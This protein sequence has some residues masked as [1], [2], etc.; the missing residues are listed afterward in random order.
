M[1]RPV[2]V[3]I[4]GTDAQGS[5]RQYGREVKDGTA[6][7]FGRFGRIPARHFDAVQAAVF[8]LIGLSST[9][10][11]GTGADYRSRGL[12]GI[13]LMGAVTLP[14]AWRRRAPLTVFLITGSAIVAYSLSGRYEGLLPFAVL[15]GAYTVGSLAP[16]RRVLVAAAASLAF[17]AILLAGDAPGFD[18]SVFLFNAVMFGAALM[19]GFSIQSRRLRLA[20]LE[21]AQEATVSRA[22]TDERLRIARELHD[23][24]A[25]SLGVIAVQAGAGM[26]VID[27]DPDEAR[28]SLEHI[29]RT[30]RSSL[31]EI[32]RLLAAVRDGEGSPGYVP[33]PGLAD[34]GRL[35]DETGEAGLPVRLVIDGDTTAVPQG[36][37]LAAYRIVQEALTNTIRH[38]AASQAHVRLDGS[39]GALR[40]EV[41]DDGRGPDG[42]AR[43]DG[44]GLVGMRERVTIYG[45]TLE[46]GSG[47]AGGFRVSVVLP[48]EREPVG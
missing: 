19:F 35:V 20:A 5:S 33:A 48:Y 39:A 29:S 12:V 1:Y 24:V 46:A 28:R 3:F 17:L 31:A 43:T 44:H 23:V 27:T 47:A 2:I 22:A 36:V 13:V 21:D 16:L 38:A 10:A 34:L 4:R 30:S 9:A 40:I 18:A 25:H 41:I 6:R 11:E 37:E 42:H 32:R 14:Y 26:H 15:F 7:W 45:G 8:L